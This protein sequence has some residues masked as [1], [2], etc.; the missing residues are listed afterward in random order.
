[1]P[2]LP[3]G[4]GWQ[5]LRR[6][7]GQFGISRAAAVFIISGAFK[8]RIL[9]PTE[10][11]T[12]IFQST[13]KRIVKLPGCIWRRLAFQTTSRLKKSAP[14]SMADISS[15]LYLKANQAGG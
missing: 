14:G 9:L 13:K 1:M 2:S 7:A 8:A 6:G 5:H 11:S 12:R 10:I 4:N 15:S 3:I